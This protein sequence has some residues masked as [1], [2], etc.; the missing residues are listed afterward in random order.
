MHRYHGVKG[1]ARAA[2]IEAAVRASGGKVLRPIVPD[3]APFEL[4]VE[5]REGTRYSL[6]CYAFTANKYRQA[7]RPSDEHRFQVKYGSE[8]DRVHPIYID[9]QRRRVTLFLGVHDEAELF[10]ACDPAMHNPSWFSSSVEFKQENLDQA[11]STGWYGWERERVDSG[12]RRVHPKENLQTES[13]LAFR[14]EH[15]MTFVQFERIATGMDTGE[16]LLL[17]DK[18]AHDVA[19]GGGARE[20]ASAVTTLASPDQHHL[21]TTFGLSMHDLLEVIGQNRRLLTAVRGGVAE[22]HLLELLTKQRSL[23]NVTKIDKDGQPDFEFVYRR[24]K[25]RIECKNVARKLQRGLPKVDF[26]KTRV[27]KNNPCSRYYSA[28]QFEILAA[29]LHPVTERWEFSYCLTSALTP[30]PK[31]KEKLSDKVLV[32]PPAWGRDLVTLLDSL[33]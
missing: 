17:I 30:H 24:T 16:R 19:R 8:F 20:L 18:I 11:S 22:Q 9:E 1:R 29:C 23:S 27:A 25:I 15:F 5:S 10:I 12:R 3:T 33:V 13:V 28:S 4:E 2:A 6:V 14:P 7:G 31:C 26:Q 21:L 32:A